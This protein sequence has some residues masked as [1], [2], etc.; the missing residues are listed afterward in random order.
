MSDLRRPKFRTTDIP[1]SNKVSPHL[2]EDLQIELDKALDAQRY[3]YQHYDSYRRRLRGYEHD[4]DQ[5]RIA[6]AK[7]PRNRQ[8]FLNLDRANRNLLQMQ[9][10]MQYV[11]PMLVRARANVAEIKLKIKLL[12]KGYEK[13]FAE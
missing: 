3:V 11:K 13:L 9:L 4:R 8:R 12:D 1:A 7:D 2:G 6:L 10:Q 5:A